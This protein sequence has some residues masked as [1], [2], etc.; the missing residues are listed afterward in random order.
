MK[1]NKKVLSAI[2][3]SFLFMFMVTSVALAAPTAQKVSFDD[4]DKVIALVD[5]VALYF[6][7]IV[8][9]IA[10]IMIIYS[11]FLW[12]T[13]GGEEDKLGTARKTLIYGLVGIAVVLFAY[14]AQTFITK[15]FGS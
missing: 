4:P 3:L 11:G 12:M 10:I 5:K 9:I 14:V 7:A 15:L 6:Q 8:L 13:A 1:K 2:L